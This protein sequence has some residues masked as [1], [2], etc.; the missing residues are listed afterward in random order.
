MYYAGNYRE[1]VTRYSH[2]DVTRWMKPP[3]DEAH[4]DWAAIENC[5]I[6]AL[7]V[8]ILVVLG[9]MILQQAV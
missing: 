8:S 6:I 5:I 4:I 9:V 1:S 3:R 7:S 2:K